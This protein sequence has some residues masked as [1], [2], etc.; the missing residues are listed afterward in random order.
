M[1]LKKKKK[2][3][4]ISVFHK[5]GLSY[6]PSKDNNAGSH[7]P[8]GSLLFHSGCSSCQVGPFYVEVQ[9]TWDSC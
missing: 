6:S 8:V 9:V 5:E 4:V 2:D 7:K 1:K 3:T